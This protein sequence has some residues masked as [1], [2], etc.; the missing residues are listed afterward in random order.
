MQTLADKANFF[1]VRGK[2]PWSLGR[3]GKNMKRELLVCTSCKS[4]IFVDSMA[5][6][7]PK[8]TGELGD[9]PN[10]RECINGQD[11]LKVFKRKHLRHELIKVDL[12]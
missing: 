10:K 4:A 2:E 11:D 12:E 6:K 1:T 8:W 3:E 9:T 7:A 5:N